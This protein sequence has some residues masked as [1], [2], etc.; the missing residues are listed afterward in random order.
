MAG[1]RMVPQ[2][3]TSPE[4]PANTP[5]T[6]R[7]EEIP[8]RTRIGRRMVHAARTARDA[9]S[10]NAERHGPIDPRMPNLPPP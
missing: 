4:A 5:T 2:P 10:I 8:S 6:R 3:D 7:G 1:T 9:T